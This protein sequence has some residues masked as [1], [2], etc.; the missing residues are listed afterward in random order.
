[1]MAFMRALNRINGVREERGY[2]KLRIISSFYTIVILMVFIVTFVL[3]V[4]GTNI[5]TW[6][7]KKTVGIIKLQVHVVKLISFLAMIFI[8]VIAFSGVYTYIPNKKIMFKT[9]IPGAVFVAAAWS[10]F[11]YGFSVYIE[12]FSA[13]TAYGTMG[14]IVLFLLWLYFCC[15]LL[16]TGAVINW[17]F[18]A[19][20]VAYLPKDILQYK[21]IAENTKRR[22]K[23]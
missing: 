1:M 21:Q 2:I 17:F 20:V 7:V 23:T 16:L 22:K 14:T 8:S 15:Y 6:V 3:G 10:I 4:F 12:Y 13:F 18:H 5:L 19:K 11:T 9:Q